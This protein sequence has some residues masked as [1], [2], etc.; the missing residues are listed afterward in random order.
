LKDPQLVIEELGIDAN[1]KVSS[2]EMITSGKD[3]QK[4]KPQEDGS[5]IYVGGFVYEA[6]QETKFAHSQW[7]KAIVRLGHRVGSFD[8]EGVKSYYVFKESK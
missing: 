3:R 1:R 6:S 5:W 2:N 7:I 4:R 8:E